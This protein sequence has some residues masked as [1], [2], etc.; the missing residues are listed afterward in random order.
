MLFNY[1]A[2][3]SVTICSGHNWW[4]QLLKFYTQRPSSGINAST[5][6][7]N[8]ELPVL[9]WNPLCIT[10][11]KRPR[12]WT[13]S[14]IS[15]SHFTPLL[16]VSFLSVSVLSYLLRL[17]LPSALYSSSSCDSCYV[18]FLSVPW[19]L[20]ASSVLYSLSNPQNTYIFLIFLCSLAFCLFS[21]S[22]VPNFLFST[23]F[24]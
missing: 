1:F 18:P 6:L 19:T 7:V 16:S 22:S 21:L 14:W 4:A 15:Y 23:S 24:S 8:E 20:Y 10:A 13:V 9:Y 17:G 5:W 12:H 11:F 3:L 2:F